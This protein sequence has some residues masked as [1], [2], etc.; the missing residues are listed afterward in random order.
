MSNPNP[1]CNSK[2]PTKPPLWMLILSRGSIA[3]GGIFVIGIIAGGWRLRSFIEKDLAP[4]AEQNLTTTLNRPV[5]LGK[6]QEFSLFGVRFGASSIPATAD[7]RDRATVEKVDVSFDFLQLLFQRRLKLDVTLINPNLYVEQDSEGRWITTK[8]TRP[9]KGS[10]IKTDLDKLRFRNGKLVLLPFRGVE[11]VGSSDWGI[12]GEKTSATSPVS[13]SSLSFDS[14]LPTLP[15]AFT[16][17]NGVAQLLENNQLVKYEVAGKPVNGGSIFVRGKTRPK[18]NTDD[19]DLQVDGLLAADV[20][21]LIKLPV[22]LQTGRVK[23]DLR[24]YAVNRR[25]PLLYGTVTAQGVTVQVK[26]MPRAFVNTAGNLTFNKTEIKLENVTSNYY[27]VPLVASGTIDRIAG[28]NLAARVNAVN[29]ANTQETLKLKFPLPVAANLNADLL[30]T[31]EITQPLLTGKINTIDNAKIDQVDF[32]N[33]T[34]KFEFPT[35][36]GLITFKDIQ[37]KAAVGGNIFGAGEVRVGEENPGVNFKLTAKNVPGDAIAKIYNINNLNFQIGAV[38]ATAQLQGAP[39]TV[40]T[41]VKWNSP[42]GTYPGTGVTIVNPDRSVSFRDVA[43]NVEGG[44]VLAAGTWVKDKWQVAANTAGIEVERFVNKEQ[45]ENVNIKGVKFDGLLNIAGTTA[46]FNIASIASNNAGIGLG[47]GR[48][49]VSN[50]KFNDQTFAAQLVANNVRLSRVLKEFAPV[51]RNPLAGTF[52]IAG[53]RENLTLKNLQG[54]GNAL[55]AVGGGTVA[56]NNIQLAKGAYQARLLINGSDVQQLAQVPPEVKGNLTGDLK[57]AGT[58]DSFQLPAIQAVGQA[59]LNVGNG[60][61]NV[62]NIQLARGRY[63]A[64]LQA[65]NVLLQQYAKIPP[66]VQ[67]GLNGLFN[68]AGTVESFKPENIQL[69][70]QGT[71]NVAGGNVTAS[72]IQ[73]KN[74][75]Y[76]ANVDASNVQLNRINEQLLGLF[77]GKLQV[78]GSVN[79]F[80]I[81]NLAAVGQVLFSRGLGGIEQPL[82]A[83]VGWN[84]EKLTVE[85]AVGRDVTADGYVL[86]KVNAAGLPEITDLNLNVQAKNYNLQ[87]LPAKLPNAI[88]LVGKADFNGKITGKLPVPNLKGQVALRDLTVNKFAFESLLAGNIATG[89]VSGL[90]LDVAGKQDRIALNIDVNNRP[91]GFG[92]KWQQSIATGQKQDD[93]NLAVK[94]DNFP[95]TALNFTPPSNPF[96]GTGKLNGALTGNFRVNLDTF[97]TVGE[98]AIAKPQVGRIFGNSLNAKFSYDSG[99]LTLAESNFTKNNSLY[100]FAGTVIPKDKSIPEVQGKLTVTQGNIQDI[101]T[102]LQMFEFADL[103]RGT[104]ETVYGNAAD[105]SNTQAVGLPNRQL[106]TQVQRLSEIQALLEKQQQQRRDASP[107]P[108]LADLTGI[109]NG[110]V[111]LD[112]AG[113]NGLTA[114]FKLNGQNFA[115]G[116][117]DDPNRYD[118]KQIIAEGNFDNNILTFRPL[119]VELKNSLIAF[120][121]S[122]GGKEQSGQ[123]RVINFPAETINTFVK[124]PNQLRGNLSGTAAIAGSINNPQAKGEL[125]LSDGTLNAKGIK[126]ANASFSYNNGRLNFGSEVNVVGSDP[127]TINGDVPYRFPFADAATENNQINL[128]VKVKN[129]G[130]AVINVLTN[131][132]AF[133]KGEGEIDLKVQGTR[134]QLILKGIASLNNAT[135]SAQA[136]PGKLTDVAGQVKFD[137]DRIIVENL[138]GKFSRG[139]VE[140]SGEIAVSNSQEVKINNPLLVNLDRLAINLKSLYQGG[141]SGKIQITGSALDPLVGGDIKLSDGKVLLSESTNTSNSGTSFLKADTSEANE[142]QSETENIPTRF[143]NLQLTLGNNVRITRAPLLDFTA[144]GSLGVTGSFT[145]PIPEGVIKLKQGGVNLFTTQFKLA[146]GYEH[147][148]TFRK[149]QPRD[150]I[151][152]IQLFAKVL[153]VIQS[154]DFNRTNSS[155]LAA[156]EG[157]RVEAKIQGSASQLND[158]LELTSNPSRSQNE[159]VSL[160]GGGFVDTQGRG[161]GSTLGLINIAGSAVFNNF[162]SAFNQIGTAFGLSEFRLFPTIISED[163]AVGRNFSSLEL[164]A[165]AGVDITSRFSASALKILTANDPVQWGV[166]YRI[167]NEFRFRSSTNFYN[168][169]RAVVEFQRRF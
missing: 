22:E 125:Q 31:G 36:S 104:K 90:Q 167:N 119:R 84:G 92:V 165:E 160:L 139:K 132:F 41:V 60:N 159:I 158:N 80:N 134:D 147:K 141:V 45:L 56:V 19:L 15:V 12:E 154:S 78:T 79:N 114:D 26:R 25:S 109:F 54:T 168:D 63:T 21:R 48:V 82:A 62:Q 146:R 71:L 5:K 129:Q 66:Q 140:A 153:D 118:A 131:Q 161:A 169:N 101:L 58:V 130:L 72:N 157:V 166:N 124:L 67:G 81:A 46:P 87:N 103:Q 91:Q 112:T 13:P 95:L 97:A 14:L 73:L 4:L 164:A 68:V 28:F 39:T 142:T 61:F 105:L 88:T 117:A 43:L 138:R 49:A 23:G 32:S 106:L 42:N 47:G 10:P 69:T 137:F 143:N 11:E 86:A 85:R 93:G 111:V 120:S 136:L 128:N 3:F 59:R 64:L 17:V 150:P 6:V 55:L 108:E 163:P 94:V 24:V 100:A 34:T 51:L 33:V 7:D 110:E 116:R 152:D 122:L 149:T 35:R 75:R 77:A 44:K 121:G 65:N 27:K 127:V 115:W 107:V 126:S 135:F 1:D 70:G 123:L 89:R 9:S 133:E 30:L 145:D 113:A 18:T 144:T 155:G 162:E 74:G 29:S 76:T 8:I 151:L 156:L 98:I 37:A 16:Q 52:Q 83:N 102:T 99:K 57:V 50:L 148:A 40:Q 96:I 2:T 20:T 53:P 38:D